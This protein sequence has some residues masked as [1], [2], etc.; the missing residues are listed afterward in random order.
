MRILREVDC[1]RQIASVEADY[2][3]RITRREGHE[4]ARGGLREADF[5]RGGLREVDFARADC[6][7]RIARGGFREADCQKRTAQEGVFGGDGGGGDGGD[8]DGWRCLRR[9]W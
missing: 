3:R 1:E 4:I 6:E 9:R 5:A 2:E 8:G 7:R